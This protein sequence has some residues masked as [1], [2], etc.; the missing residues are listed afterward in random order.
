MSEAPIRSVPTTV[1][2]TYLSRK[3]AAAIAAATVAPA[4]AADSTT[5]STLDSDNS[6]LES[7]KQVA[8]DVSL[9]TAIAAGKSVAVDVIRTW[10][11]GADSDTTDEDRPKLPKGKVGPTGPAGPT[12]PK[13]FLEISTV[14]NPVNSGDPLSISDVAGVETL[15]LDTSLLERVELGTCP[16]KTGTN[17]NIAIGYRSLKTS[18]ETGIYTGNNVAVGNKTLEDNTAGLNNT[19]VGFLSLKSNTSGNVNTAVGTQ[20]LSNNTT[21][22]RNVG[23]GQGAMIS[24]TTGQ[25]N[26]SVGT[27]SGRDNI[28]GSF[29]TNVGYY[30]GRNGEHFNNTSIGN[31]A[32][33]SSLFGDYNTAVGGFSMLS[34]LGNYST[35][36]GYLSLFNNYTGQDNVGVGQFTGNTNESGSELTF[37][38]SVS[39]CSVDGLTNSTAL[40][41][42]AVVTESGQVV[43]GGPGTTHVFCGPVTGNGV[44]GNATL[45]ADDIYANIVYQASDERDK[46][47]IAPLSL[48]LDFINSLSPVEY[49]YHAREKGDDA[50]V[51]DE[52]SFGLL[53]QDLEEKLAEQGSES[54]QLLKKTDDDHLLISY[55][56]LIPVLVNSIKELSEEVRELKEKRI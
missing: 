54:S 50:D 45:H 42:R 46:K 28:Q 5:F 27:L 56:S 47:N 2:S 6:V 25:R 10:Y 35:A 53:A 31:Q 29:N 20:S 14:Q 4:A 38:G 48:S 9:T 1:T 37:V 52:V 22:E 17:I 19:A 24:N 18:G 55:Q 39:N 44:K 41:S 51:T 11:R 8:A 49:N 12:G 26:T 23:V 36:I 16:G 32:Q 3:K 21:G 15:I 34:N 13:C 30:A 40:G 33:R 7:A 43:L